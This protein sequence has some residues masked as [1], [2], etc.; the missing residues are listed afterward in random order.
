MG[1]YILKEKPSIPRLFCI[2]NATHENST[3][4]SQ[5]ALPSLMFEQ[6]NPFI[7]QLVRAPSCVS[8]VLLYHFI[9]VLLYHFIF[10]TPSTD[11]LMMFS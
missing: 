5:Q 6:F 1:Q 9:S 7:L 3:V 4:P 8:S 11:F 2:A 10:I